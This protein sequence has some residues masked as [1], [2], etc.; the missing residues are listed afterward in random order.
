MKKPKRFQI[1]RKLLAQV[2]YYEEVFIVRGSDGERVYTGTEET[3]KRIQRLL[4][5]EVVGPTDAQNAILVRSAIKLWKRSEAARR[6]TT[7]RIRRKK[8]R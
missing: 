7:R 2:R 1:E 3:A 5:Y 6:R 8:T 4:N